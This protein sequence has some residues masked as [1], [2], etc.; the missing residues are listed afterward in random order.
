MIDYYYTPGKI[1]KLYYLAKKRKIDLKEIN[2]KDLISLLID[3]S[4]YKDDNDVK[5]LLFE[6]IEI[7]LLKEISINYSELSNYFFKK[8]NENKRFNLDNESLFLEV[9]SKILNG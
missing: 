2:L 6:L 1:Y 5:N 4:H 9:N 8:I 3:K 7:Y